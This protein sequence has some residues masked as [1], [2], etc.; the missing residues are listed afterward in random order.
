MDKQQLE[1]V[2]VQEFFDRIE[3]LDLDEKDTLYMTLRVAARLATTRIFVHGHGTNE[4]HR[5]WGTDIFI[6]MIKA[7]QKILED[8]SPK[9]NDFADRLKKLC[10]LEES[11]T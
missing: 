2:L 5:E 9:I 3:D 11:S 6:R 8:L 7:E 10:D 1:T 4:D